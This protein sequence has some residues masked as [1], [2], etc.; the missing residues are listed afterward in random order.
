MLL[1]PVSKHVSGRVMSTDQPSSDGAVAGMDSKGIE[2][3]SA[4]SSIWA[5]VVALART[6]GKWQAQALAQRD[7]ELG[8]SQEVA[9]F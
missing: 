6:P 2:N 4:D 9:R 5:S 7:G 8:V 3:G 1:A